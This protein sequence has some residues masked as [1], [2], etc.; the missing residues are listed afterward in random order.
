MQLTLPPK[1]NS[2]INHSVWLVWLVLLVAP[3]LACGGGSSSSSDD[4]SSSDTGTDASPSF[5]VLSAAG[6]HTCAMLLDDSLKCWGDN[7]SGQLGQGSSDNL[8]DNLFDHDSNPA[9][10]DESEMGDNLIAIALGSAWV[11]SLMIPVPPS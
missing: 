8:G 3:L 1:Y 4:D 9:T 6:S 2:V 5:V 10:P 7:A 11:A